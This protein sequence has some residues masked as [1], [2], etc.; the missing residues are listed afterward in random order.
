[1]SQL[2]LLKVKPD[3]HG[4]RELT[5]AM[6]VCSQQVSKIVSKSESMLKLKFVEVVDA[7]EQ[8]GLLLLQALAVYT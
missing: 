3:L 2:Q 1:M 4:P 6:S 8:G 5:D 7:R